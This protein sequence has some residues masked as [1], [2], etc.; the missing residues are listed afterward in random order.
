MVSNKL[1]SD[2]INVGNS[3]KRLGRI[4]GSLFGQDCTPLVS[5]TV[6]K[7]YVSFISNV[8]HIFQIG[9]LMAFSLAKS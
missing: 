2:V 4:L 5:Y 3:L 7:V 8:E 1:L 6:G 9:L